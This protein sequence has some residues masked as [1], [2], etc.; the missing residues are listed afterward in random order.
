MTTT[1]WANAHMEKHR[2]ANSPLNVCLWFVSIW[3]VWTCLTALCFCLSDAVPVSCVIYCFCVHTINNSVPQLVFC[4]FLAVGAWESSLVYTV[5]WQCSFQEF[6]ILIVLITF[7]DQWSVIILLCFLNCDGIW[8]CNSLFLSK[9]NHFILQIID[10]YV[11]L[12]NRISFLNLWD[13]C[14]TVLVQTLK[15]FKLDNNS[16]LHRLK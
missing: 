9:G 16:L 3:C 6:T 14:F 2:S 5:E 10:S 11:Q 8:G 7:G 4:V 15:C 12:G 13:C 1:Y